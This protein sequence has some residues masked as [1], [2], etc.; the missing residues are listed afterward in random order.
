[1]P[2]KSLSI[3]HKFL[4]T[5]ALAVLLVAL[6]GLSI[7]KAFMDI[8]ASSHRQTLA[9]SLNVS[10]IERESQHLQWVNNLLQYLV[11]TKGTALSITTDHTQCRFGKWYTSPQRTEMT[12]MFPAIA[13]L[14][15]AIDA[16]HKAL[17]SSAKNIE[18]ARKNHNDALAHEIFEKQTLPALQQVQKSFMDLRHI[19]NGIAQKSEEENMA[20]I[21]KALNYLLAIALLTILGTAIFITAFMRGILNPIA[22]VSAYTQAC[23]EGK[24][25]TLDITQE[26]EIGIMAKN[27]HSLQDSL[28]AQ[29]AYSKGVLTGITVPCS[30]F[31]PEDKTVFTNRQMFDLLGRSGHIEDVIGLTSGEYI[32]NDKN[33]LTSSSVA[34]KEK[35]PVHT[36]RTFNNHKGEELSVMVSSS[37][38]YD[39]QQNILGTLS[40]WMDISDL[41]KQ[42]QA[43]EENTARIV[44]AAQS[45]QDVAH[46]V[47]AAS[48]QIAAQTERSSDGAKEQN[49]CVEDAVHTMSLMSEMV[50]HVAENASNASN[51]AAEAMEQAKQGSMVMQQM[52]ESFHQVKNYT[53]NVKDS[54]DYLGTQTEGVGAI[55]RVIT[56]IADQTNLLALNAA[57]EAAR[58]GEAGRGFAVVADEVRKLAE[59]TMQATS[60]V[61]TVISGIQEG[62]KKSVQN[63]D[64]AVHAVNNAA[65]L[66][67]QAGETLEHIVNVAET[68]ASQIRAIATASEEQLSTSRNVGNKLE[69]VRSI[70]HE[71][72][73]AMEQ[74]AQAVEMLAEQ[75]SVLNQ[76]ITQLK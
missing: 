19:L 2:M 42:Q 12:K 24:K 3:K 70:S 62:T 9:E 53:G 75:A 48:T 1:M 30:V 76:T 16:P 43:I 10:I 5:I 60:E 34:L 41:K 74:T 40:I 32:F 56:D 33:Q 68:T 73:I 11:N 59:K 37:P 57:I 45:A 15:Q 63:V 55:I 71:T 72:T 25:V 49:H 8:Q 47:S 23:L 21:D 29:L 7:F 27:L 38:F 58:A 31:S 50:I 39:E 28:A 46:N 65:D 4:G 20:V 52:N 6:C 44:Q 26:D 22:K 54:M 66:A 35:R 18:A 14:L 17:H 13:P 69:E 51:T 67:S 36:E 64:L 61:S